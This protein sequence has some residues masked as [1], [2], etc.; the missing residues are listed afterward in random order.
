[1]HVLSLHLLAWLWPAPPALFAFALLTFFFRPLRSFTR[2]CAI[3][4]SATAL[5]LLAAALTLSLSSRAPSP[6][7]NLP[8]V[9]GLFALVPLVGS[10]I[11]LA[12]SRPPGR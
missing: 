7:A 10:L 11:L 6:A 8:L 3:L 1:M 2:A 5:L 12:R 9:L 4:S